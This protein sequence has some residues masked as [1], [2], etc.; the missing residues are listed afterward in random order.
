MS[1]RKPRSSISSASSST[2]AF[3]PRDI[4]PAAPQMIA[5]PARR[6]DHDVGARGQF[7]LLAA[8]IHAADAGDDARAG[9]LIKPCQFAMHLQGQFPGRRDDQGQWRRGLFE[10]LGIAKQVAR[11]GEPIGDGLA[12][13][14]LR[15]HQ[16]VAADGV[17]RQYRP[18]HR[19]RLVV[20]A[21]RQCARERRTCSHECHGSGD[22][23]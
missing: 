6:A 13:A 2:T 10:P 3:N 17:I 4:E 14:G 22:L 16:E 12:R 23:G 7:A 18:L 8:R 1:S 15:R 20:I 21:L 5:Q 11:D 9:I 19:R